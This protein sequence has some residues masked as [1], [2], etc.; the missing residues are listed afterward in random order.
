VGEVR[1][2][3]KLSVSINTAESAE[4]FTFNQRI[5]LAL[6]T[7]VGTLIVRLIG[8]TLRYTVSIEEGGPA[9]AYTRPMIYVFWHR[10]VIPALYWY[11][12]NDIAVMT[13]SSFDGEYIARIIEKFGYRAVRGSSTRGGVRALLGMHTEIEAGRSVAFTI[14]GPQGPRYVAKPGAVLLARNVK[15]PVTA[16]HCAVERAWVLNSW[17]RFM[18]PKP[19]SRVVLR[20]SRVVEVAPDA[21]GSVLEERHQQMQAAL[22]RARAAAEAVFGEDSTKNITEE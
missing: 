6:I 14:D 16:F 20:V 21:E 5:A 13:S 15:L 17:D 2:I 12:G 4:Q 10:C 18:I 9:A 11:R 7:F 22:D 1:V 19:F 8:P 3:S